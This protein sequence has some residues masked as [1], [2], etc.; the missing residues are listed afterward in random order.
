MAWIFGLSGVQ[1][2]HFRRQRTPVLGWRPCVSCR[3]MAPPEAPQL[4][5][6]IAGRLAHFQ[7]LAA[8]AAGAGLRIEG[9]VWNGGRSLAFPG[10]PIEI[11]MPMAGL[12]E[13][14]TALDNLAASGK[15]T[16]HTRDA[17][18]EEENSAG[19][20][21]VAPVWSVSGPESPFE[22]TER[23]DI[24]LGFVLVDQSKAT[25]TALVR[26]VFI[27]NF[28][29]GI[30]FAVFFVLGLRLL[31]RRLTQ[32]LS[33]LSDTMARAEKGEIGLRA[34]SPACA[35]AEMPMPSTSC[36]TPWSNASRNCVRRVNS[37]LRFRQAQGG[38]CRRRSAT[39][40]ARR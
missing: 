7:N 27:V 15:A 34:T 5:A 20:R 2:N 35:T 10:C 13:K 6:A 18:L 38:L 1:E 16:L 23:Q 9:N 25:L 37:A 19:W 4:H 8:K 14:G 26:E 22:T 39:K 32:P 21:F 3:G 29:A 30:T 28:A 36:G 17:Y 40:Y 31:A 24:L 11:L 33:D 12:L